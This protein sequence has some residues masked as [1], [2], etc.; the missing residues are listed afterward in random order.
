MT[1]RTD[2][3]AEGQGIIENDTNILLLSNWADG[4][5]LLEVGNSEVKAFW[6]NIVCST[7]GMLIFLMPLVYLC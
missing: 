2:E 5:L 7:L 1:I 3:L 4:M 6:V